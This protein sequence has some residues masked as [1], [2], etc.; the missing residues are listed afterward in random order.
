[1]RFTSRTALVIGLLLIGL[2]VYFLMYTLDLLYASRNI[3]SFIGSLVGVLV[4]LIMFLVGVAL[5]RD[6]I[7]ASIVSEGLGE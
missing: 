5:I 7:Y 3:Y 1:M 6:S 2:A 4:G